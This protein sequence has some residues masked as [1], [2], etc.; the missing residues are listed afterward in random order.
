MKK[1]L[2]SISL[3]LS[4]GIISVFAVNS[5]NVDSSNFSFNKSSKKNSV[6][7]TFESDY[8]LSAKVSTTNEELEE[9]IIELTKKTTYLL[10]GEMNKKDESSEDYH[11]RHQEY[12]SLR[13][14]PEIPKGDGLFGYDD[15]S[16]EYMDD[17]VSGITIPTMFNSFNELGIVYSSYGDI[18]VAQSNDTVL[19]VITLPNVRMKEENKEEPMK[20]NTIETNLRIYYSFKKWEG[21]YKLYYLLGEYGDDI[22]EYFSTVD[23]NE[24]KGTMQ[25]APTYD[26]NLKNIY[27]YSKLERVTNDELNNIYNSNKDNIVVLNSHY[28]NYSIAGANGFY[29]SDGLIVTSWNFLE[30]SL[31]EAQYIVI[32]DS[33]GNYLDMEGIVTVNP[34]TDIAVIKLKNK[35]NK[36]VNLADSSSL[37]VEDPIFTISSKTGVG[38]T[39]QTGI[40]ISNDGYIQSAI[41]LNEFDEGS[42]LLNK[43]GLVVGMN[44]SKQIN[45]ATSLAVT[46]NVLKEIQDKFLNNDF[47]SIKVISF[48][49]L[50]EKYY[51]VNYNEEVIE[52]S[53]PKSKWNTYKKIGDI[54]DTISLELVKASYKDGVVSLR[55]KNDISNYI[56]SMQLSSSFREELIKEGYKEVLTSGDKYV[57]ENNKYQVIIM[58][59]FDYLIVVM[60]KL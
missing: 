48:E 11:K 17:M 27:D 52:N 43:D 38:L 16:Q 54:E 24:N 60:V 49:E 2:L 1:I 42:P 18:R 58:E 35:T 34:E 10:L 32:T 29:I 8:K 40:V 28:N 12:L 44:T 6:L 53:I 37:K 4:V 5:F 57:Y 30:K 7:N 51:Y 47:G 45:S 56:S 14:A 59:E 46:S 41:P 33:N 19:S 50:K 39:V 31:I 20:Y 9:E 21:E 26:S 36:K 3:F 55:Y 22:E 15:D 13:Y 23:S 25:L